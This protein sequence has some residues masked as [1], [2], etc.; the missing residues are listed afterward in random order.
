M[1][2]RVIAAA[3]LALSLGAC[4]ASQQESHQTWENRQSINQVIPIPAVNFSM[5][6][7]VLVNFYKLNARPRLPTCTIL[8]S[9]GASSNGTELAITPSFGMPVNLSNQ[10]TS[11]TESEPDS[12][13]PGQN[14]QTVVILRNGGGFVS[15]AD[16]TTLFGE[17]PQGAK[18]DT[19]TQKVIDAEAVKSVPSVQILPP[20]GS[21][22]K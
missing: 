12:V 7:W 6:R 8:T 17:C 21:G 19:L 15:E 9:R 14:D 13:Y 22:D 11:P 18:P 20:K 4:D 5:R 10:V 16:T 1:K 2:I 3:A